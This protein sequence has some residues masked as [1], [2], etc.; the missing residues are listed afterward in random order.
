MAA[1]TKGQ[2][3]R[4]ER[5]ASAGAFVAAVATVIL[6]FWSLTSGMNHISCEDNIANN[7]DCFNNGP[8]PRVLLAWA[9]LASICFAAALVARR[10]IRRSHLVRSGM[11]F[12]PSTNP[13]V[14]L[15]T[16][17]L[18][19]AGWACW[20]GALLVFLSLIITGVGAVL[21]V[22]A[23]VAFITALVLWSRGLRLKRR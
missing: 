7:P 19:L 6:L 16:R 15:G 13:R 9:V 5:A 10:R 8:S 20:I 18:A 11:N 23:L 14:L 17:M 1:A 21:G 2:R 3:S 22:V 4:G 12:V